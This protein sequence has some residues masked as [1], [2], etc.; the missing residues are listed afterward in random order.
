[1]SLPVSNK[2]N[3]WQPPMPCMAVLDLVFDS[4]A[5]CRITWWRIS[6]G[7]TA[8]SDSLDEVW[9]YLTSSKARICSMNTFTTE[10]WASRRLAAMWSFYAQFCPHTVFSSL[11]YIYNIIDYIAPRSTGC[12]DE[13]NICNCWISDEGQVTVVVSFPIAWQR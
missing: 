13:L 4:D 9:N 6:Q 5:N 1:M 7:F 11:I 12:R 3:M 10:S 8:L 2:L